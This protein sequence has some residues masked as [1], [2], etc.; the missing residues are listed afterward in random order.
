[1]AGIAGFAGISRPG[2]HLH[3]PT[4]ARNR[5]ERVF[6]HDFHAIQYAQTQAQTPAE[7]EQYINVYGTVYFHAIQYAQTQ[8]QT[9][10]HTFYRK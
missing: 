6:E 2:V 5:L 4:E 1:M 7:P 8:A 10:A 3:G 9:P